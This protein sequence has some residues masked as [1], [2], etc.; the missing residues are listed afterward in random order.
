[1]IVK[2][3]LG[4]KSFKGL[5]DYLTH[6][7]EA[8]TNERVAWTH[9]QN[10]ANDHVPSA[11]DEMLWTA[12]NAELLKQEAGVRAGGRATEDPVKHVSLNWSPEESP[13]REHMIET[14]EGFLRHMK[15]QE[16][17]A[18]MVAHNDKHPHVHV[19]I[20]AIH[21]ETGLHLDD[22]LE[23]RRAQAW[24]LEYERAHDRIYCEQRLKNPEERE[25]NP[26]RNIW[27]AFQQ[28]EKEFRR[29][30]KMLHEKE[31]IRVDELKNHRKSEWT[32]LKE[33]QQVERKDFFAQGKSEFSNLRTSIYREVREEFRERWADYYKAVKN[34]TEDD[35]QI[36]AHVKAQLIADRKAVLEPR[37]D[38][39][40]KEIRESRDERYREI[41]GN[42]REA[43]AELRWRQEA[44]LDNAPFFNG[45]AEKS[46][47][48]D[49]VTAG[50]REAAFE[51]TASQR[52]TEP[53]LREAAITAKDDQPTINSG[54][55]VDV[56]VVGRVGAG[57]ASFLDALFF[58]LITLGGGSTDPKPRSSKEVLQAAADETQKRQQRDLEERDED[59]R[60]RQR[61]YGE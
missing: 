7:P 46:A 2:I 45:L 44:G 56:D 41:L 23:R 54:R 25:N 31:E 37:R 32:I 14:T 53:A 20:N 29:A 42:Q 47:A 5:S 57:A 60:S 1:M 49:D 26:P 33:M 35:R 61:V 16:H 13:T 11:V 38:E 27:M 12:R 48:R 22:G 58:D 8:N 10:L 21:P 3:G 43:R 59:G 6:D 18:V 50:F 4:G 52:P 55:D 15:W 24:A 30:E 34:G 9:T 39:A 17:Q 28:N 19:M 36:L 40:C 51:A